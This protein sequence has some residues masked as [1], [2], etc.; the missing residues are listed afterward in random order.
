MVLFVNSFQAERQILSVSKIAI[1]I[2]KR[3]F[4]NGTETKGP[5]FK[6]AIFFTDVSEDSVILLTVATVHVIFDKVDCGFWHDSQK[7]T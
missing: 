7:C 1:F 3:R 2:F 4:F 6:I 5:I